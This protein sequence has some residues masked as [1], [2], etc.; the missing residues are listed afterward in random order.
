MSRLKWR[1][2]KAPAAPRSRRHEAARRMTA[3]GGMAQRIEIGN[4]S[5]GGKSPEPR[6]RSPARRRGSD[7]GGLNAIVSSRHVARSR[8]NIG[9]RQSKPWRHSAASPAMGEIEKSPASRPRARYRH[10]QHAKRNRAAPVSTCVPANTAKVSKT[11]R[12]KAHRRGSFKTSSPKSRRKS[13][14]GESQSIGAGDLGAAINRAAKSRGMAK[15][16][17]RGKCGSQAPPAAENRK[18]K[19]V[20]I[21]RR[22]RLAADEEHANSSRMREAF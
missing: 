20:R 22:H 5:G 16:I 7:P 4:A 18:E 15:I 10:H 12:N 13:A 19:S 17:A 11:K 1:V 9:N 14:G 2:S 6:R 21:S 3:A 8:E